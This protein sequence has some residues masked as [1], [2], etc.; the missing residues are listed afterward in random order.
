VSLNA[1]GTRV[2]NEHTAEEGRRQVWHVQDFTNAEGSVTVARGLRPGLGVEVTGFLRHLSTRIRFEDEGRQPLDWPQGDIHHRDETLFG[3]GDP[4]LLLH[5][6]R[7]AGAWTL[8]ARAGASLPLGR[9]EPNPFAL[10]R[11]GRAHQHVQFG[12]GTADP[13]VGV[14]LGRRVG[15]L[16]VALSALGRFGVAT[17]THGYR[18][19]HRYLASLE[20]QRGLSPSWHVSAALQLAHENAETWG[21]RVEE[22]GNLG[23]TDVLVGAAVTRMAGRA[24][25]TLSVQVPVS[26]RATGAQLD[27]PLVVSLGVA[28]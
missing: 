14:G 1:H 25:L 20:A 27:Y 12:T 6:A 13:L 11:E 15:S 8:A 24:G 23:R 3:P 18:P 19:G 2:H 10:G 21:G 7:G 26:T 5:A 9:T 16:S 4:W 17:N 22:E 28:R